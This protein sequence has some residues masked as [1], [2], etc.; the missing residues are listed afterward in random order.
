MAGPRTPS[1]ALELKGAFKNNPD[2]TRS[3]DP[4]VERQI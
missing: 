1:E 2:R 4:E 3:S